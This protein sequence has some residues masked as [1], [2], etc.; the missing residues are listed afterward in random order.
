MVDWADI[1]ER[2]ERNRSAIGIESIRP[3][4]STILGLM[5]ARLEMMEM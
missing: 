4:L 1:K 2:T 5:D 3:I